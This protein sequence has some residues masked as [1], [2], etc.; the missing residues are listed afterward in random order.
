MKEVMRLLEKTSRLFEENGKRRTYYM[1]YSVLFIVL[2]FC[3]F[4][5]F[6]VSGKSLIWQIDGWNQH[7][8]ALVY[9][10]QY[11]RRIIRT[12]LFEH[13]LVIPEWDFNIGEGGDI[14]TALHYYVIGDP[15]AML[16]VFVPTRVMHYFFSASCVLRLYLSGIAFSMLCFGTGLRDRYGIM[17]GAL[18]YSFCMW[19]LTNAARH[20]YF[21]NP[22]IYFP[23]IIL[24]I[25]KIIK[26]KPYLFIIMVT[27]SA[28]S[29][30]YFFYMI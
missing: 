8:K 30:F 1:T 22:M 26:K 7:F 13:Q 10:A 3:C 9:Y 11:L 28:V 17:A 23:L 14:L 5:W 16:S 27:I 24:G 18:T 25:E 21:L 20:P 29:N 19:G 12:L 2:A 15:I 6:I 4:S